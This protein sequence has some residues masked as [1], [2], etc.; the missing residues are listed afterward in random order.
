MDYDITVI[1]AGPGGY[2]AAITA[3]QFDK[4]VC[5][6]ERDEV[7]GVCLSEGCIPTKTLIK[8][9]RVLDEIRKADELGIKGID[10]SKVF[11]DMEKLQTRKKAI[12]AKLTG[13]VRGLLEGNGVT[14]I[15]G[16]AAFVDQNTVE[17]DGKMITSDHFIIATGSHT[18]MPAAI[19]IDGNSDV[20]T[21][22]EALEM[23]DIPEKLGIIGGG[24][25]G[26]ELAYIFS[27]LGAQVNVIE[28]TDR[29]LPTVDD[30]IS[31][32]A[33]KLL[34]KSGI[35]FRTG[36]QVQTI[37]DNTVSFICSGQVHENNFT[38]VIMAVGRAPNTAGLNLEAVGIDL[39]KGAIKT[40]LSMKTSAKN[41]Y[42]IGDVTGGSMLAHTASHEGIAAVRNI[43]G[44]REV[45]DHNRIPSCIY[46]EPEIACIGLTEAQ[47]RGTQGLDVRGIRVGR[48][49]L[50]GNGKALIDG[51]TD[52]FVKVVLD[53]ATEEILGVHII[54]ANAAEMIGGIAVAMTAEAT[55]GEV[56]NAVFPHPSVS[57]SIPEAFLSA[58]GKAIHWK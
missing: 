53:E 6:I 30:E 35:S 40:D 1:G 31:A 12:L 11:A 39:E 55:A 29:I 8:T 44:S 17:V 10:Q 7:G 27:A 43:C 5:I 41:I 51:D 3:A 14:L 42:A 25:I 49:P 56:I 50:I 9:V 16:S 58:Y 21:S 34:E 33:M 38:K 48:F 2:V 13:G 36:A 37:R 52:G 57:E 18:Q 32:M 4:R 19:R 22:R 15:K 54:G 26:I 46:L 47:A 20:I 28:L 45:V 24:V 23:V